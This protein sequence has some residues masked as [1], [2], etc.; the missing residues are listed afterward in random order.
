MSAVH[1]ALR[2][3]GGSEAVARALKQ[4]G[5]FEHQDTPAFA[6]L[7]SAPLRRGPRRRRAAE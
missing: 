7:T 1:T 2:G 6:A 3:G 4:I 5:R